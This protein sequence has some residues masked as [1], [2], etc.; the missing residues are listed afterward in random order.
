[1]HV[2][3]EERAVLVSMFLCLDPATPVELRKMGTEA[4]GS[5]FDA[6][7]A[8]QKENKSN[9]ICFSFLP[10]FTFQPSAAYFYLFFIFLRGTPI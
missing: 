10:I 1:M 8:F 7:G 9:K 5:H 2:Q 4:H 3:L 6:H